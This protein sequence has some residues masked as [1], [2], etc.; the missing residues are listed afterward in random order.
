ML[1]AI[2]PTMRSFASGERTPAGI[3]QVGDHDEAR[4]GRNVS[5]DFAG[6][7]LETCFEF[8]REAPDSLRRDIRRRRRWLRRKAPRSELRRPARAARPWPD[9]WP[10]KC[11]AIARCFPPGRRISQ[12]ALRVK[13]HSRS[14]LPRIS[15]NLRCAGEDR[16]AATATRRWTRGCNEL[17][18][19]ASPIQYSQNEFR[20][21]ADSL[22]LLYLKRSRAGA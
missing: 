3:V 14:R 21:V 22:P 16:R 7:E 18:S 4:A 20:A 1:R 19:A 12:K 15:R 10:S 2:S 13:A 8:S 11:P 9:D 6:V 17:W 5:F